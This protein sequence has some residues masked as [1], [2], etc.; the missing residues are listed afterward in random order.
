MIRISSALIACSFCLCFSLSGEA[1]ADIIHLKKG[2]KIEGVIV[3]EEGG[4]LEIKSKLGTI[5]LSRS[6]VDRIVRA[7]PEENKGLRTEW[8][9]ERE[10]R[11]ENEKAARKYENEQREKGM[12]KYKGTWIS[13]KEMK[14]IEEGVENEKQEAQ[15]QLEEQRKLLEEMEARLQDMEARLNAREQQLNFREQQ[16]SIREQNLLLQQQNLQQQA[17]N[18]SRERKE[19]PAKIYAIPRIEV[20]P[21]PEE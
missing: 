3:S 10:D 5:I 20:V 16:L 21:P 14:E 17:E 12:V 7:S 19:G 2:G 6:A 18:L 11:E 9:K 1:S 8:E 13:A 4:S 15:K